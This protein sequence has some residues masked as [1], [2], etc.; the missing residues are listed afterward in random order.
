MSSGSA[1]VHSW[2][3][4]TVIQWPGAIRYTAPRINQLLQFHRLQEHRSNT[5]DRRQPL[6]ALYHARTHSKPLTSH[7]IYARTYL[8]HVYL[9]CEITKNK[10]IKFH[11]WCVS[12]TWSCINIHRLSYRIVSYRF[13]IISESTFYAL[14]ALYSVGLHNCASLACKWLSLSFQ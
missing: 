4:V 14:F 6:T 13:H 7:L 10:W 9:C 2:L 11:R 12:A 3:Q 5:F 1:A 8:R